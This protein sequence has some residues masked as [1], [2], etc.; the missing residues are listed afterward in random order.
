MGNPA[1]GMLPAQ[2]RRH[3]TRALFYWQDTEALVSQ[4][5]CQAWKLP[6]EW[7]LRCVCTPAAGT[8][9]AQARLLAV[10]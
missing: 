1:A 10:H 6:V 4:V 9:P 2:A 3:H 8:L 7:P 5:S